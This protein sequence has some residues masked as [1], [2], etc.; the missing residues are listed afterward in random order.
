M[1][2]ADACNAEFNDPR[3]VPLYDVLCPWGHPDDFFMS[4]AGETPRT[5]VLD[6]GCGTGRLTISLAE[7]GYH[8]TGVDPAHNSLAVARTKPGAERVRWL[9]GTHEVLPKAAFDLIV[10]NSHVAQFLVDGLEWSRALSSFHQALQ[11]GGRLT[12]DS[13]DPQARGWER[14]NPVDSRAVIALP[15]GHRVTVWTEVVEIVNSNVTFVTHYQHSDTSEEWLSR[16]T[17]RFRSEHELRFSLDKAGFEIEHMYGGWNRDPIGH[18]D[19]EFIVVA[20][21]K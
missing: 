5:Q 17:L 8:V 14:W 19:G 1:T 21:A 15:N 12:F 20:R 3:L 13:R 2:I 7:A 9:E 4:L 16:S 10:M 6:F 18:P 11:L